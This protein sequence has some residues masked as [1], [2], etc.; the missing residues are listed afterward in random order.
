MQM[1]D[2]IHGELELKEQ[3]VKKNSKYLVH[4][5]AKQFLKRSTDIKLLKDKDN[6]PVQDKKGIADLLQKQYMSVFSDPNNPAKEDPTFSP[7]TAAMSDDDLTFTKED[8]IEAIDE[9]NPNAASGQ[10]PR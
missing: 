7:A 2:T 4:L 1:R 3:E 8:V 9:V 10:R 6:K 5:Y